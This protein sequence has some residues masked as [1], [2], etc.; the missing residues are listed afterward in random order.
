[1]HRVSEFEEACE[2]ANRYLVKCRVE[3][4]FYRKRNYGEGNRFL[5]YE[6]TIIIGSSKPILNYVTAC[7]TNFNKGL[8]SVKVRARGRAINKAV[9]VVQMVKNRFMSDIHILNIHID[10]DNIV[11]KDGR[12]LHLPVLEIVLARHSQ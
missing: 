10:G 1:V 9:E 8:G 6:E 4:V 2:T 7:I 11:G 12:R 3:N 5:E